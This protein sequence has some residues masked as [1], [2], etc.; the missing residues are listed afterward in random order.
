VVSSAGG[1]GAVVEIR[2]P[3]SSL[4]VAPAA[5]R[6]LPQAAYTAPAS[7]SGGLAGQETRKA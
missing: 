6:P 3:R 5:E 1:G 4:E 2:W 7:D